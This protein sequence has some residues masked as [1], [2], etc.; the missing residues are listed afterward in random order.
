MIQPSNQSFIHD[1]V[2]RAAP[3]IEWSAKKGC[4]MDTGTSCCQN[5]LMQK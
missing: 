4:K 3:G 2:C 5:P 1:V